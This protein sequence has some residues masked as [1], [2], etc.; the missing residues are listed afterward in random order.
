[1]AKFEKGKV[2]TG[3]K[4]AGTPN[5]KTTLLKEMILTALD[6]AGGIEYLKKQATN[7]PV[8][9]LGLIGKILPKEIDANVKGEING[10]ITV[11][12]V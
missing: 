3:G 8:A 7:E 6:D 2:K 12:L 11:N 1:M 10:V 9:F 4:K 5:K